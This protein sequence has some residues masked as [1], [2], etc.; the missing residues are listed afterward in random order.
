LA[1]QAI[2]LMVAGASGLRL[3]I[4]VPWASGCRESRMRMGTPARLAGPSVP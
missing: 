2:D 4:T 1:R 3:P